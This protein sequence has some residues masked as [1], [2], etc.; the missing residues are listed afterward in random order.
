MNIL[1]RIY[2][3]LGSMWL[4]GTYVEAIIIWVQATREGLATGVY[5][6]KVYTNGVG[7]NN[8][9]LGLFV[10]FLP[11]VAWLFVS[12]VRRLFVRNHVPQLADA[13]RR[14]PRD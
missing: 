12:V 13:A 1:V 9:E 11:A 10:A 7:E 14:E 4:I 2:L 8:L 3:F 5:L 6:T